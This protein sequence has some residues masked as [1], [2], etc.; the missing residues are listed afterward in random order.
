MPLGAALRS[1]CPLAVLQVIMSLLTI[2]PFTK[3][4]RFPLTR[5][6]L[7]QLDTRLSETDSRGRL[8]YPRYSGQARRSSPHPPL[9]TIYKSP[10]LL[11]NVSSIPP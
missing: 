3:R 8:T 11:G 2:W 4:R 10:R 1:C 7:S 5:A 9:V 6:Q